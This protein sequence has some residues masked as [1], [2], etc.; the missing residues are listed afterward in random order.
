[1]SIENICIWK[2][3]N[4]IDKQTEQKKKKRTE[5]ESVIEHIGCNEEIEAPCCCVYM[6]SGF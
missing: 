3:L 2:K 6:L 1:M 4:E 5:E